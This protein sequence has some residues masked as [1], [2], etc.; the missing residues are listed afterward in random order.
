MADCHRVEVRL[1]RSW[2]ALVETIAWD[3]DEETVDDVMDNS[4]K[5]AAK[6]AAATSNPGSPCDTEEEHRLEESIL[7]SLGGPIPLELL[8]PATSRD[9]SPRRLRP[10]SESPARWKLL[11][12]ISD[13]IHH[14]MERREPGVYSMSYLSY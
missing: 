8:S 12:S 11:R 7:S 13:A 1:P 9:P 3:Y 14:V 6:A 10:K 5:A 4:I 2:L